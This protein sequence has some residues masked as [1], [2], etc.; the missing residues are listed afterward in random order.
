MMRR[1]AAIVLAV[2]ALGLVIWKL[3]HRG[4]SAQKPAAESSALYSGKEP[5]IKV[6]VCFPSSEKPGFT[7]QAAEIY[8]TASRG[9]Q[10]KQA[11]QRLFDGP[12][13]AGSARGSAPSGA[14]PAFPA[15]FKYREVFV[16]E[17]GLAVVDLDAES[18]KAHP[19]GTSSEFVS[20]YCLVKTVLD[21]FRDIKQV[22]VLVGGEAQE[23]LAG[24]IDIS[25][26][27]TLQDF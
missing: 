24:H 3:G 20:L 12:V 1:S 4:G 7:Q 27:L 23:S 13:G 18:V 17:K 6:Q 19:G 10:V 25:T 5:K 26:P 15:G 22:Q 21:N 14:A 8:Q 9:A 11:L 16:T 2:L